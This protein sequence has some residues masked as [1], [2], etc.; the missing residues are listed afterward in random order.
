M[1]EKKTPLPVGLNVIM[2]YINN[3]ENNTY[4]NMEHDK[5][6]EECQNT[7]D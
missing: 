3:E 7:E 2:H 4:N 1:D 5:E 6:E